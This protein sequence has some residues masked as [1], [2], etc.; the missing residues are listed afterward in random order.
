MAE[1]YGYNH[2]TGNGWRR[3]QT[4][5]NKGKWEKY[6]SHKRTGE[7]RS[8]L[9]FGA[10]EVTGAAKFISKNVKK[11]QST[12]AANSEARKKD[13]IGKGTAK[14]PEFITR[15]GRKVKNP[16]F[17]PPTTVAKEETGKK[18]LRDE[19]SVTFVCIFSILLYII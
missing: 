4:G 1:T 5:P 9:T 11:A 7:V 2:K 15:R 13:L 16:R 6:K 12:L 18:K 14:N 8:H 19:D 17:K 3:V 10:K